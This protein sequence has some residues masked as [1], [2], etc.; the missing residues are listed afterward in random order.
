MPLP[1]LLVWV[2]ILLGSAAVGAAVGIAL[3]ALEKAIKGKRLA[4]LGARGVGKTHLSTF[5]SSGS[6]PSEYIQTLDPE[7]TQGRR[8]DLRNLDIIIKGGLDLPG[9]A[10]ALGAWKQHFDDAHVVLYLFRVDEILANNE[11][12]IRRV[13]SDMEQIGSW[14]RERKKTTN[15]RPPFFLIGTHC[16]KDPEFN[17]LTKDTVGSYEDKF[18]ASEFLRNIVSHAGGMQETKI[19]LGSMLTQ[20]GTEVLVHRFFK[21]LT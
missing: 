14:L 20:E 18:K 10:D 19:V 8:F 4:I 7:K 6:I 11:A 5:L 12:A 9:G 1:I 17:N 2:A 21:Q 3:E 16:D 13:R 15:S